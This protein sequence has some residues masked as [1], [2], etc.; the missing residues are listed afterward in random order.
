[1]DSCFG[2][3]R[4]HQHSTANTWAQIPK[5]PMAANAWDHCF[6]LVDLGVMSATNVPIVPYLVAIVYLSTFVR[7]SDFVTISHIP[8]ASH[9]ILVVILTQEDILVR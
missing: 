8:Q 4:P 9:F 7:Y 6:F 3:V 5:L 1:M 2:L